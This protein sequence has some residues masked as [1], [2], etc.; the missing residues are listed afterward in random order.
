MGAEL[1]L[2]KKHA[3]KRRTKTA[4][5]YEIIVASAFEIGEVARIETE[6]HKS[7]PPA[8]P[9]PCCPDW[10]V[11]SPHHLPSQHHHRSP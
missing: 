10:H 6:I 5:F 8:S 7:Y 2:K 1:E 11:F 3:G 4:A 9:Q